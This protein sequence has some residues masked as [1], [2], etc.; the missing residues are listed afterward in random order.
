MLCNA[1]KKNWELINS[2]LEKDNCVVQCQK[3]MESKIFK[4]Y[5][6][7]NIDSFVKISV[8]WKAYDV[9]LCKCICTL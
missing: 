8:T 6:T 3:K 9:N 2:I 7:F 1:N 5:S 4:N